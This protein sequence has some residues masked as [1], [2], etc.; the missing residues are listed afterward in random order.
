MKKWKPAN[1]IPHIRCPK[2]IKRLVSKVKTDPVTGCWLWQGHRHTRGYGQLWYD[3]TTHQAHR[4]SF[5][6]F[7]GALTYGLTV[8]H[9]CHNPACCNPDH[10]VA[11]SV[12]DNCSQNQHCDRYK[13]CMDDDEIPI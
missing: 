5:A 12:S 7:N 13:A 8:D 10:L 6:I 3:G 4:I 11:M 1:P 2:A 9:I